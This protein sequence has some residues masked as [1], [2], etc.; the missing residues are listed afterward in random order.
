MK[1][2]TRTVRV[3]T[4][5]LTVAMLV[6]F[7]PIVP[8]VAATAA[9]ETVQ[10]GQSV[11]YTGV[12]GAAPGYT[13]EGSFDNVVGAMVFNIS[14]DLPLEGEPNWN[15]W[16]GSALAV[17]AGGEVR[18]Y[19]FGGR[20]VG[21]GVDVS[22]NGEPDTGG[23]DSDS[24]VGSAANG[25]ITVTV[26]VNA[27][28]F[29][30]DFYDNCWDSV[31]GPHYTINSATALF[32]EVA[33]IE[34]VA[35]GTEVGYT[36][37]EGAA[38]GYEFTSSAFATRGNVAAVAFNINIALP[39]DGDP[40]WNDWCGSALA[41]RAGGEVRYYDF[42]GREVGWG[43]DVSGNGEPDTGGKD[44][45]SWV[46]FA[47]N[48]ALS[49]LVP[50]DAE[51]FTVDFYDN[52]W[53]SVEEPHYVIN[54]A[55]ALFGS[56]IDGT[57]PIMPERPSI[58]EFD[59]N[60]TYRAFLGVQMSNWIFR[61]GWAD[62]HYGENG[63]SWEN[64][65]GNYFNSLFHGDSNGTKAGAFTDT[66]INGNGTYRVS[67]TDWDFDGADAFNQLFVSTNIPL[68]GEHLSFTDVTV[69]IG[70][71]TRYIFSEGYIY[72]IDNNDHRDYYE[73]YAINAWNPDLN[74]L[75][76]DMVPA[77]GEIAIEFTVSG[78][79]YDKAGGDPSPPENGNAGGDNTPSEPP[80]SAA[81]D[82]DGG[83][84]G[85]AIPVIIAGIIAVGLVILLVVKKGSKKT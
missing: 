50:I 51:E 74:E 54:Y 17:R 76:N 72:G 47:E 70:G 7:L 48:G 36:G 24:W 39:L 82:A 25:V 44:S 46:G 43:V 10:I 32:G 16:C 52:C 11:G 3:L 65:D 69:M 64:Y 81:D 21:W 27:A 4:V 30:V 53:D 71:T 26:P 15:D 42:G 12:E 68:E 73:I 22:G 57:T 20:E 19:D 78:F 31:E 13:F 34:Q 38:P 40:G 63:S 8:A 14:I 77:S 58:P 84:P 6:A 28:S 80:P 35:V 79:N 56:V 5:M 33:G 66:E 41:V 9:R 23:K 1:N 62:E 61:N 45:D 29:A 18:Y 60:G 67:L 55:T 59:P 85:W 75:F 37:V 2:P 49:I 83:L